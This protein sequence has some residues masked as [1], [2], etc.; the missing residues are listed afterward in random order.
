MVSTDAMNA[1]N[2]SDLNFTVK[3]CTNRSAAPA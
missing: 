1:A 2:M 3:E